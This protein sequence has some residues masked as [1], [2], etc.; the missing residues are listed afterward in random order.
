MRFITRAAWIVAALSA[1]SALVSCKGDDSTVT[2]G[3][4]PGAIS[5]LKLELRLGDREIS[6]VVAVI[7]G[8][9][10]FVTQTHDIDVNGN[11]GVVSIYFG[12]L[13]VG[14]GYHIQLTAADCSGANDFD[15]N[16]N[17]TTLVSVELSCGVGPSKATGS[18][19]ITGDVPDPDGTS[20]DHIAKIF[21][22]PSVQNGAG[23][24]SLIGI[25]LDSGVVA[26]RIGWAASGF[27][28]LGGVEGE[29]DVE[30][31]FVCS[32]NGIAFVSADVTALEGDAPCTEAARVAI[33]CVNQ[34]AAE[35]RCGDGLINQASEACDGASLPANAPAGSSCTDTC[36]LVTPSS[37]VCGDG[38]ITGNEVCDTNGD[39]ADVLAAGVEPGSSC[40][41][42]CASVIPPVVNAE[43]GTCQRSCVEDL[44]N[45]GACNGLFSPVGP[46]SQPV[47]DCILGASWP[48]PDRFSASSCANG[49][50][51]ACY[52]G[53]LSPSSC[54]TALP[55]D[56]TAP[57]KNEIL[58]G[59]GCDTRPAAEQSQCVA[60]LFVNPTN[61][62]GRAIAFVQCL[63]DNCPD[64]CFAE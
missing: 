61:A 41:A 48:E 23:T 54:L 39:G 12:A 63:Q 28:S 57:C 32:A 44:D 8:P 30:V 26:T 15:V 47:L 35:A 37:P 2:L 29:A 10:G 52:C 4:R 14:R 64:I 62:T 36:T 33:E 40:S 19:Q 53:A 22:S 46:E 43:S 31:S 25:E 21:A 56:I 50:L 27:G 60:Q 7:S 59:T 34:G 17:Q 42:D 13:P 9:N 55:A 24:P 51:L 38:D 3:A 58:A 16:E 1:S 6:N 20:C 18:V 45:N 49:N 11:S 5:S